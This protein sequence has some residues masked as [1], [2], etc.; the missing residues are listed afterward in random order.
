MSCLGLLWW[1]WLSW[2]ERCDVVKQEHLKL[3]SF[4]LI[5]KK[6]KNDVRIM[7]MMLDVANMDEYQ[8]SVPLPR[9]RCRRSRCVV[10]VFLVLVLRRLQS[11]SSATV[12]VDAAAAAA[13]VLVLPCVL[14]SYSWQNLSSLDTTLLTSL[15]FVF[16]ERIAS[17]RYSR[18]SVTFTIWVACCCLPFCLSAAWSCCRLILA[19]QITEDFFDW[20]RERPWWCVHFARKDPG[21]VQ[22]PGYFT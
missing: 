21:S 10:A 19:N 18:Q 13:I 6:N 4:L 16:G 9:I 20:W 8:P 7:P 15:I 14:W 3:L 1:C 11:V 5:I 12:D 17:I 22:N 2:Y